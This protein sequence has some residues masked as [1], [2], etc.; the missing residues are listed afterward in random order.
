MSFQIH[1]ILHVG[2]VRT[3]LVRP[4]R[5]KAAYQ[6]SASSRLSF[7]H[8]DRRKIYREFVFTKSL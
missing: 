1:L 7:S 4:T 3:L 2:H 6:T 5:G 8:R